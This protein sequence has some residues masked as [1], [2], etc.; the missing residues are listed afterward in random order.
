MAHKHKIKKKKKNRKSIETFQPYRITLLADDMKGS[1]LF[2]FYFAIAGDALAIKKANT[3]AKYYTQKYKKIIDV[4]V[5]RSNF[6]AMAENRQK[7]S[8]KY[9]EDWPVLHDYT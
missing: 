1:L 3:F 8:V 5:E 4:V 2:E 6:P 9:A 7:L